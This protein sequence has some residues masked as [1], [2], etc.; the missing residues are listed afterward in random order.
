MWWNQSENNTV[1]LSSNV[2]EPLIVTAL[3]SNKIAHEAKSAIHPEDIVYYDIDA[4]SSNTWGTRNINT[5]IPNFKGWIYRRNDTKK[6]IDIA[7][8]WRY[9]TNNCCRPD[10]SSVN[11]YNSGTTYNL[12]DVVKDGSGKLYYSVVNSNTNKL[13]SNTSFWLPVS[14][15]NESLTYFSTDEIYGFIAYKVDGDELVILPALVSTRIQQP[16]FTSSLVSQG[17]LQLTN[18]NNIKIEGGYNNVFLGSNINSNTI[19][20]SFYYNTIG[21]GF[22]YNTIGNGFYSNTIGNDF[23]INT[24]GSNFQINTIGSNFN[25]NTIG[26]NFNTNTIEDYFSSNTVENYFINNTI[27]NNFGYN[28]IGSDFYDN[29]IGN[30]FRRNTIEN[31]NITYDELNNMLKDNQNAKDLKELYDMGLGIKDF[32]WRNFGYKDSQLKILDLGI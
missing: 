30:N 23:Q 24:I 16:T 9:I 21:N 7:W 13:L 15:Y 10:M 2:V 14:P 19:G 4:T 29:T 32:H 20:N 27:G 25:N 1:V 31:N 17:T 18:C 6:N 12:Y 8:D 5:P 11:L 28:T 22:Y 26:S 3:S